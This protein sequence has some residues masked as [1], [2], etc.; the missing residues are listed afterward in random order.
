M[1]YLRPAGRQEI[2][3]HLLDLGIMVVEHQGAAGS[4]AVGRTVGA[5]LAVI[6]TDHPP[7]PSLVEAVEREIT[8]FVVIHCPP[9]AYGASGGGGDAAGL[10]GRI[11]QAATAA[12]A[13]RQQRLPATLDRIF[14]DVVFDRGIPA[15][16]RGVLAVTLSRSECDVLSRLTAAEGRPVTPADLERT[17]GGAS[18]GGMVKAVVLRLRRKVE[19]IGGNPGLLRTVRG[20]GYVLVDQHR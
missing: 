8:P 17:L 10:A 1:V 5:D 20:V 18:R 19:S 7:E 12:R 14:G 2:V 3:S 6:V 15:L 16:Q 13:A 9:G 11:Q 4:I